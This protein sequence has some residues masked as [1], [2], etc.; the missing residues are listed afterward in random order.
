M[1]PS[2]SP[3]Q[4]PSLDRYR[5]YLHLLAQAQLHPQVR[6]QLDPSDIV[7]ETLLEAHRDQAQFQGDSA[8]QLAGWL[9]R[10]LANNVQNAL[11]NLRRQKRDVA[12][13]Q[14]LF[15]ENSPA[16]EHSGLDVPAWLAADQPTPSEILSGSE[17]LL[18][19][20]DGLKSL[21]DAQAQAIVLR[22]WQACSLADIAERM[23]RSPAAVAGLLHRGLKQLRELLESLETP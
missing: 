11:R 13:E 4:P 22:Y 10:I 18:R 8:A 21:S 9:R 7:Q 14:P 20:S 12:R 3:S 19:L 17:R 5:T 23:D 15:P 6:R 16:L 2:I 1:N